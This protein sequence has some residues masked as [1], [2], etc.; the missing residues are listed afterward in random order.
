MRPV[1]ASWSLRGLLTPVTLLGPGPLIRVP[2]LAWLLVLVAM[3]NPVL[4]GL[5]MVSEAKVD[6][7]ASDKDGRMKL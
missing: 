7:G 4:G 2:R 1:S 3:V 6:A 5:L